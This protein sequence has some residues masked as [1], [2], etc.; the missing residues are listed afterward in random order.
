[1]K[2]TGTASALRCQ[3]EEGFLISFFFYKCEF[4]LITSWIALTRSPMRY[5][6]VFLRILLLTVFM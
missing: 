6:S 2:R 1:M 3:T 5:S 4:I